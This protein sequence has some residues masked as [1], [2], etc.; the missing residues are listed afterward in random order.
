M[1]GFTTKI[2]WR[3]ENRYPIRILRWSTV[4][5]WNTWRFRSVFD[6]YSV[7]L[8]KYMKMLDIGRKSSCMRTRKLSL[9]FI[10][11]HMEY[12][13]GSTFVVTSLFIHITDRTNF[14]EPWAMRYRYIPLFWQ[15]N[16]PKTN[17]TNTVLIISHRI[18]MRRFIH[19]YERNSQLCDRRSKKAWFQH[20][21][22]LIVLRTNCHDDE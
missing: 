8:I 11:F 3:E 19:S 20:C 18:H 6:S 7:Y 4:L 1:S 12:N 13:R 15:E 10:A 16:D 14:H 5:L 21:T 9:W 2:E 17:I 22:M